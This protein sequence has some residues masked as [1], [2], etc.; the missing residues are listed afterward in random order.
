MTPGGCMQMM[1]LIIKMKH[2]RKLRVDMTG[3]EVSEFSTV[4]TLLP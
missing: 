3:F 2:Q 1:K 4:A